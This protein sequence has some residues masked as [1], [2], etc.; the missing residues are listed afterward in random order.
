[1]GDK[2]EEPKEHQ[3]GPRSSWCHTGD[4]T[5]WT[6][7]ESAGYGY[8]QTPKLSQAK[9]DPYDKKPF[10]LVMLANCTVSGSNPGGGTL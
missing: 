1:M 5:M 10:N 8:I 4:T 9:S 2:R 6:Q 3:L 7:T